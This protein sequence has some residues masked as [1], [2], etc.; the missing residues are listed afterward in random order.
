MLKLNDSVI[1]N[2]LD[3]KNGFYPWTAYENLESFVAFAKV[4]CVPLCLLING[5]NGIYK[6]IYMKKEFW[7]EVLEKGLHP[8][9]WP[10]STAQ[11][12]D[13]IFMDLVLKALPDIAAQKTPGLNREL[14]DAK[15]IEKLGFILEQGGMEHTLENIHT[16]ILLMAMCEVAEADV[17][18]QDF[19]RWESKPGQKPNEIKDGNLQP[20]IH[21]FPE[22]DVLPLKTSSLPYQFWYHSDERLRDGLQIKTVRVEAVSGGNQFEKACIELYDS[23][24]KEKVQTI[25]LRSGEYRDCNISGGQ[26]IKFLPTL[27]LSQN[28]CLVRETYDE[29][30]LTVVPK[31]AEKWT[32]GL[33][34][35]SGDRVTAFAAGEESSQGF[36]LIC[37][38]KL[39]ISFYKPCEVF[40]IKMA[41]RMIVDC[42]VEVSIGRKGYRLLTEDGMVLSDD[43]EWK[44]RENVLTLSENGRGSIQEISGETDIREVVRDE[45][46]TALAIRKGTGEYNITWGC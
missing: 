41:L 45:R 20:D 13:G 39:I 14:A 17:F 44:G 42:L 11:T 4:H 21:L 25:C 28:M 6:A 35:E 30:Q 32:L 22:A 5:E 37:S 38:G 31:D 27:S 2:A 15:S 40:S 36:L 33:D 16:A 10:E 18:T 7:M 26:V 24:T 9:Q 19:H 23:Y 34:Q 3:L 46:K 12:M 1:L 43:A 8:E 29:A